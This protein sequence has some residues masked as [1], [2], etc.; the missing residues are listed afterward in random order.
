MT[1]EPRFG[2]TPSRPD[3]DPAWYLPLD[4]P[5]CGRK[6]LQVLGR[7]RIQCEKCTASTFD[8]DSIEHERG[9]PHK[10]QAETYARND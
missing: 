1:R 5:E 8:C 6:R 3:R 4:C 2:P 9:G 10:Q 7:H